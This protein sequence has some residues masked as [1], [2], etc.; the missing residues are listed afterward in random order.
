MKKNR[1]FSGGI[2]IAQLQSPCNT[3]VVSSKSGIA[4]SFAVKEREGTVPP[5]ADFS[6]L[7]Y[8]KSR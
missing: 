4:A 3:G 7:M 5:R 2:C 8:L 1:W 6:A